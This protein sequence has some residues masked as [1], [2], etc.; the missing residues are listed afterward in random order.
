MVLKCLYYQKQFIDKIVINIPIPVFKETE[1]KTILQFVKVYKRTKIA[2]A[3]LRKKNKARTL[4]VL[5][6][7]YTPKLQK[8]KQFST[9]KKK[10]KKDTEINGTE[11]K[12]TNKPSHIRSTSTRQRSQKLSME[13]EQSLQQMVRGKL[14]NY[15]QKNETESCI[16]HK[17]QFKML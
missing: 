4:H 5:I 10:K 17:N 3:I 15:I 16:I 12:P 2:E 7:K 13:K 14:D 6:S 11:R 9:G 1:K 8:S